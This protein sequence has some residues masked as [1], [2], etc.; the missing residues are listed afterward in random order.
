M[1]RNRAATAVVN[2]DGY[3]IGYADR[4]VCGY[5]PTTYVFDSYED[6]KACATAINA[7]WELSPAEVL[8]IVASSMRS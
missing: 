2:A 5:T 8:E 7:A 6:A 1:I 3:T 4:G